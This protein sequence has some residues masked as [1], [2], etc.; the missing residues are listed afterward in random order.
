MATLHSDCSN[1]VALV[2]ESGAVLREVRDIED[3]IEQEKARNISVNLE[4]I[5]NDLKLVAAE[6]AELQEQWNKITRDNLKK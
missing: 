1:L 3:Q 5:T 2:Q 6:G 4:R